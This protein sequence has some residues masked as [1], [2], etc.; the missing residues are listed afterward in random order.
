MGGR[1][2]RREGTRD[3]GREGG[4]NLRKGVSNT[5]AGIDWVNEACQS[6]KGMLMEKQT[7]GVGSCSGWLKGARV[8]STG[9]IT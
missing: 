7:Q 3:A 2:G 4:T 5:Y 8:W 1:E 6:G 9:G